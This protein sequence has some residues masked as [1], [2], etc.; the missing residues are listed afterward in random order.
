M[1]LESCCNVPQAL[2]N[3]SF[4]A[5]AEFRH[6]CFSRITEQELKP[7]LR[8]GPECWKVEGTELKI[9][10]ISHQQRG[11]HARA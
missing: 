2:M 4:P 9:G 5:L 11:S 1:R 6:P 7:T 8:S 3:R 10:I